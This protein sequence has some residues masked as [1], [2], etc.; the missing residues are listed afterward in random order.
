[1]NLRHASSSLLRRSR[2][3]LWITLWTL[4]ISPL[5]FLLISNLWLQSSWGRDWLARQISQRIGL[6]VQLGGAGWLPGGQL[7]VDDISVLHPTA[8]TNQAPLLQIR[9]VSVRPA[10][11]S[12]LLGSRKISDVCISAPRLHL[13]LDVLKSMLP[14]PTA[15]APPT[16]PEIAKTPTTPDTPSTPPQPPTQPNTSAPAVPAE[17]PSPTVWLKITEGSVVIVHPSQEKPLLQVDQ[18]DANFPVAGAPAAGHLRSGPITALGQ[19]IAPFGHIALRWQHPLWESEVTLL[20]FS[21]LEAE[22]KFQVARVA[23]LPFGVMI[24]Q[25]PQPW[26]SPDGTQQIEHVQSKHRL[27]GFLLGPH[28]WS[29]ESLWEAQRIKGKIAQHELNFFAAQSRVVLQGGVFHCTDFRLLGDDYSVLGNGLFPLKGPCLGIARMTAP[30]AT[31]NDWEQRWRQALPEINIAL[32]PMF[33]EDRRAIDVV[34]GGTLGQ[35]WLSF[36]Q[37]KTMLDMR[38]VLSRWQQRHT[39]PP[40]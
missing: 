18:I 6:P 15:P 5:A 30:R 27:S 14:A 25:N 20:S 35:P 19:L 2:L 38:K 32:Q 16:P 17:P 9:C 13:P 22:A 40:P 11:G 21:S 37:G 29:G 12:W 28:T 34:C 8:A 7:W 4:L 24:A 31:A 1:M 10:W 26:R 36:D 33:N 39:L 23:G 3:W